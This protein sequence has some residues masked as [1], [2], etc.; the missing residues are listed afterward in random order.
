MAAVLVAAW[1]AEHGRAQTT[2]YLHEWPSGKLVR[3]E[4][5]DGPITETL[6]GETGIQN[7]A[8]IAAADG[9]GEAIGIDWPTTAV[10]LI[11]LHTGASQ[12]LFPSGVPDAD[13]LD[14]APDGTLYAVCSTDT[15][16]YTLDRSTGAWTRVFD[17]GHT[18]AGDVAFDVLSGLLL[19]SASDGRI[20]AIDPVQET[21]AHLVT[22]PVAAAALEV[23]AAGN[24]YAGHDDTLYRVDRA[25]GDLTP[26][27]TSAHLLQIG[28]CT[29]V[30][31][32]CRAD[33]NGDGTVDTR[34][35]LAFLNAWTAGDD[36]AD[37]DG[38]GLID[39]RDVLAFL[40]LWTAGC[41]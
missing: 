30:E 13:G 33:F 32:A 40:N 36:A 28:G 17:T 34:D 9:S 25:T 16:L 15:F 5:L 31:A 19:G 35:V 27:L 7:L 2:M 11:D 29:L 26:L 10:Y 20:V 8:D 24:I 3:V 37:I 4:G 12:A 21:T 23:D 22:M 1:V 41:P 38:N 39:T 14:F 6:V 18:Y